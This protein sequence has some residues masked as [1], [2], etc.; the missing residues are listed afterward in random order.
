MHS[1]IED[2]PL[3]MEP[4]D[5]E[6]RGADWGGLYTRYIQLPAGADLR[7]LL[8]GLPDDCCACPHWGQVLKGSIT[9]RYTD[10]T[11]ET[12]R[13]GDLYYWPGGHTGW[14]DEGVTF[15]EFSPTHEI[16]P[17]LEHLGKQLA[18]S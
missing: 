10:G 8:A 12:S 17:V 13:A 6:L 4:G 9:V 16:L 14:T 11:E 5:I 15:L 1:T 7:P 2:L 18:S 3:E